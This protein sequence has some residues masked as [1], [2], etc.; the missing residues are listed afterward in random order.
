MKSKSFFVTGTDTDV[1]K[2]YVSNLLLQ[3]FNRQ[4]RRA[5]G[6]K[7]I[8]AGAQL[9]ADGLRNDDAL[10]LQQ[11]SSGSPSYELINPI[12]FREPIAPHIAAKNLGQE[13]TTAQLIRWWHNRATD[14]QIE[15]VEGAG[16]WRLPINDSQWLSEFVAD[17]NLD[18]LLVVGMR[19][20]CLNHALLTVEAIK[21]DGLNLVGWVAN[22]LEQPMNHY[23]T[24]LDYLIEHIDAPFLGEVKTNQGIAGDNSLFDLSHL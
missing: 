12:C 20:G 24:N 5:I 17:A 13:I 7:P 18:V 8:A 10:I 11:A 9:S 16:G 3:Q 15:L 4:G 6:Y 1:G 19:L 2:T 23:Q 21:H 14:Y 22:Q